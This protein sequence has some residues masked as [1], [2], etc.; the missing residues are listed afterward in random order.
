MEF[1]FHIGAHCTDADRLVTALRKSEARLTE[2][3]VAVPAPSDYRKTMRDVSLKLQGDDAGAAAQDVVLAAALGEAEPDR[4]IFA[5]ESFICIGGRALDDGVIYTKSHKSLWLRSMFPD[6]QVDF[7]LGIRNPATW[8][9]A[10]F[11][12][13]GARQ[14]F[15]EYL[16]ATSPRSLLWSDYLARLL[17]TN[18]GSRII[19]WCNE[20]LP[21]IWPEVLRIVADLEDDEVM[22]GDTDVLKEIMR[23]EGLGKLNDYLVAN[24]PASAEVR[25]EITSAF[26]DNF[27]IESAI[28]DDINLPGWD[29][30]MID[31]LSARY[32]AD[33]DTIRNMPNVLLIEP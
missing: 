7:A 9:P 22:A 29:Q 18:P 28:F 8:I 27:V 24:P 14:T 3:A 1:V 23:P 2:L 16:G 19:T 31:D 10:M 6:D 4:V 12:E 30:A 13:F 5:N 33:L 25:R 15:A 20:D 32:Q 26:L 17:E 11:A 21:L